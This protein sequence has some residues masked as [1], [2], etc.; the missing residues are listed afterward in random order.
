MSINTYEVNNTK[1][2]LREHILDC[3][4]CHSKC[5]DYQK[6][7]N[8]IKIYDEKLRNLTTQMV[9]KIKIYE[10]NFELVSIMNPPDVSITSTA[11]NINT[12][13]LSST[14]STASNINTSVISSSA[15][16]SERMITPT[17]PERNIGT[18]VFD[19]KEPVNTIKE[20]YACGYYDYKNGIFNSL[21]CNSDSIGTPRQLGTLFNREEPFLCDRA[22]NRRK[23]I[24]DREYIPSYQPGDQI[25]KVWRRVKCTEVIAD[26]DAKRRIIT[27][28]PAN[29][30]LLCGHYD[31]TERRFKPNKCSNKEE[32]PIKWPNE[33]QL[34]VEH[35]FT[36]KYKDSGGNIKNNTVRLKQVLMSKPEFQSN[37]NK[38]WIALK[39]N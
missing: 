32:L 18:K 37:T 4:N 22:R 9:N 16:I 19:K 13:P 24:E 6:T 38:L 7:N 1:T 14:T 8:I 27:S 11:S 2:Q 33:Y 17:D 25:N 12:S 5:N 10:P 30:Q 26:N 15:N 29:N 28:Q 23:L 3:I 35:P 21:F 20:E 31:K 34:N 36:C 39:C